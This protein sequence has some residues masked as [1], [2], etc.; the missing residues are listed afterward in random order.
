MP[1]RSSRLFGGTVCTHHAVRVNLTEI[2]CYIGKVGADAFGDF[3]RNR[4]Q[5]AGI[6]TSA[7]VVDPDV[8]T[9][10]T[11]H[12]VRGANRAMLTYPGSIAALGPEELHV[13][14]LRS[15][16]HVHVGS[17]FLQKGIQRGLPLIFERVR[18]AGATTSLDPGWDPEESWNSGLREVLPHT[19]IF[20][21]NEQELLALARKPTLEEALERFRRIP[22]IGVKCGASGAVAC[23]DGSAISCSSHWLRWWTLQGQE[24]ASTQ[25]FVRIA[26]RLRSTKGSGDRLSLWGSLQREI[27]R[28]RVPA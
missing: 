23:R 5:E 25:D 26:G 15:A 16:R 24:T 10:L 4:L 20:L 9:G 19:N 12:L 13:S 11:A 14:V 27:R 21:P 2:R 22:M 3:M 28:R 1:N 18:E 8:K 7:V 6:D 17:Y